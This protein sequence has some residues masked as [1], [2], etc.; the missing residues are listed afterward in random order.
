M[1][2]CTASACVLSRLSEGQQALYLAALEVIPSS[3]VTVLG[4]LN[5]MPAT[6]LGWVGQWL[7]V[8]EGLEEQLIKYVL[9]VMNYVLSFK[10]NR[11]LKIELAAYINIYFL[12][13]FYVII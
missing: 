10:G 5:L 7:L 12:L 1:I 13:K 4:T 6:Y 2:V 8:I 11:N 9:D 3:K